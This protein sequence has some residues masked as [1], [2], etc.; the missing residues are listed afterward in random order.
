VASAEGAAICRRNCEE[1]FAD[2]VMPKSMA[3]AVCATFGA[4]MCEK[5][6]TDFAFVAWM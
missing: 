4:Q 5:A 6:A 3:A 2:V 1:I